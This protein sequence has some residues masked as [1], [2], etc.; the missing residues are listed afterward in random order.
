[1]EMK[2]RLISMLVV[3]VLLLGFTESRS[4]SLQVWRNW[5]VQPNG[6]NLGLGA[7]LPVTLSLVGS[8]SRPT[9]WD[10][11]RY[12]P[13]IVVGQV[14]ECLVPK[15]VQVYSWD[16]SR[17]T[18]VQILH[19]QVEEV[20]KGMPM[21]FQAANLEAVVIPSVVEYGT[22]ASGVTN[23]QLFEE[24]RKTGELPAFPFKRMEKYP[25]IPLRRPTVFFLRRLDLDNPRLEW[26][27][28][29]E[30]YGAKTLWHYIRSHPVSPDQREVKLVKQYLEISQIKDRDRR[31][32]EE[33]KF[34]LNL[35]RDRATPIEMAADAAL[36]FGVLR[37]DSKTDKSIA[38]GNRLTQSEIDEL[39]EIA[40]D[41]GRDEK[42]R[43]PLLGVLLGDMYQFGGRVVRLAPFLQMIQNSSEGLS[44]RLFV[45]RLLEGL[46]HAEV[47]NGFRAIL[48]TEPK[49]EADRQVWERL[50]QSPLLAPKK[51]SAL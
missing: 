32:H 37:V 6:L 22:L 31:D 27:G 41:P 13:V 46:S 1:M 47:R 16:S 49:T 38:L 14:M 18:G 35:L 26:A 19:L 40:T 10:L 34:S 4:N 30:Y 23:R 29:K 44:I 39:S 5:R 36:F 24:Y 43:V 11:C 2:Q 45:I 21:V 33:L 15:D 3:S 50:R 7:P 48:A 8:Q 42:M 51:K 28:L 17:I 25:E 20:L 12:M 9:I